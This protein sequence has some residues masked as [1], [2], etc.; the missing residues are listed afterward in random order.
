[1]ES[2]RVPLVPAERAKKGCLRD[3]QHRVKMVLISQRKVET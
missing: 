3:Y 2:Q 1:M